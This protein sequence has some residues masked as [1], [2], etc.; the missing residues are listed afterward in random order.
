MAHEVASPGSI[1][2]LIVDDDPDARRMY[3]QYLEFV[4]MRVETAADGEQALHVALAFSPDVI[5]MD[6]AMPHVEGDDAA[7]TLKAD[8][9]TE[10]I[11]IIGLSAYG[12]LARTKAR[13]A[14][15]DVFY[16]KPFLPRDLAVVVEGLVFR[17]DRTRSDV[18]LQPSSP[19]SPRSPG[20]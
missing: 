13:A 8:S 16:R 4:G 6:I 11:R 10:H 20:A 2:V 7:A 9:R 17:D 15:F 1:R 12:A 18:F 19:P 14:R 3:G 5:V